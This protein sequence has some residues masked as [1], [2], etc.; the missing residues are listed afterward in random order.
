M[1]AK[2]QI[3][4][5]PLESPETDANRIEQENSMKKIV[6]KHTRMV[7][8]WKLHFIQVPTL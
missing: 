3:P 1:T 2:M 4:Q 5:G 6:H 7:I 8:K